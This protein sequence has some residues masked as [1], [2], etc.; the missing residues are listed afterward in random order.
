MPN[1]SIFWKMDCL[2]SI[3]S[4]TAQDIITKLV[5]KAPAAFIDI[6]MPVTTSNQ[7]S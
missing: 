7:D 1:Q 2:F 4:D 6:W 5:M 3:G